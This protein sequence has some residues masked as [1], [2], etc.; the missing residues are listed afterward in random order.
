MNKFTTRSAAIAFLIAAG[1]PDAMAKVAV[2]EAFDRAPD[3]VHDDLL[4]DN[5]GTVI[6]VEEGDLKTTYDRII[7]NEFDTDEKGIY[8]S[9]V[10]KYDLNGNLLV[11]DHV[12]EDQPKVEEQPKT[13][14]A[15]GAGED[16]KPV[17]GE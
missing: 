15:P 16:S 4:R 3:G 9:E 2:K 11:S 10:L 17:G 7:A 5:N 6:E 13:D 12:S 1:S 14:A 8:I